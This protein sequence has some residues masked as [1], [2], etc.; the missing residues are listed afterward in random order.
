[1]VGGLAVGAGAWDGGI[2]SI[3]IGDQLVAESR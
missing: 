3:V 2:N 1:M